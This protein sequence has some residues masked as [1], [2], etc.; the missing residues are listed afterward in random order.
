[1]II[2]IDRLDSGQEIFGINPLCGTVTKACE[3][4]ERMVGGYADMYEGFFSDKVSHDYGLDGVYGVLDKERHF[5]RDGGCDVVVG[6]NL[7]DVDDFEVRD[8]TLY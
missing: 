7:E 8:V 3:D 1:M 2:L 5:S 6:F 4:V